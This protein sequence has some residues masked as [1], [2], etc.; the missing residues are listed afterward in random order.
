MRG[1]MW[2]LLLASS[3]SGCTMLPFWVSKP[4]Q[5]QFEPIN[6]VIYGAK[7]TPATISNKTAAE[8]VR[9]GY[10]QIG[11]IRVEYKD[12]ECGG[13]PR[14]CGTASHKDD[15]T[16]RAQIEAAKHGGDLITLTNSSAKI[17]YSTD[18][19]GSY[20]STTCENPK[21]R[22]A[23]KSDAY[24]PGTQVIGGSAIICPH[25]QGTATF[26]VES[27]ITTGIVWRKIK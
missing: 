10:K 25:G 12:K 6:G 16:R 19:E 11:S 8:L 3:I 2:L 24:T 9:L 22:P 27:R 5:V 1:Y 17:S 14:N 7:S 21:V 23:V 13:V 20:G 18:V 26:D 4:E 15:P